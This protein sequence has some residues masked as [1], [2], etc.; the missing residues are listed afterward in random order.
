MTTK[1]KRIKAARSHDESVVE[2]LR[3]DP[4]FAEAYV[5]AAIDEMDEPGGEAALFTAL[6]HVAEARGGM[7][8][9]ARK[10]GLSRE[11]L[12]KA[13]SPKGNPSVRT[14]NAVLRASGL[15]LAVRAA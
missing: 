12:Y 1:R 8:Q 7:A 10:A 14:L 9:I 13:L 2:M 5:L 3:E 4:E 6:R 15:R 11:S